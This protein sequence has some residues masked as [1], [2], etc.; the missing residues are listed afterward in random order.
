LG[1]PAQASAPAGRPVG[2]FFLV[3]HEGQRPGFTH[4]WKK[5]GVVGQGGNDPGK[6]F[7]LLVAQPV[8]LGRK[9]RFLFQQAPVRTHAVVQPHADELAVILDGRVQ[10]VAAH[11]HFRLLRQLEIG[12]RGQRAVSLALVDAREARAH[13][14]GQD[15]G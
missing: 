14:G 9:H 2:A 1:S 5:L 10:A 12:H 7:D 13:G 4:T 11:V 15:E 8:L 6:A 3:D